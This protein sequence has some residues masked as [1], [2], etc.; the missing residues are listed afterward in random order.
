MRLTELSLRWGVLAALLF[1]TILVPFAIWGETLDQWVAAGSWSRM[2]PG[3]AAGAGMLLLAADVVLPIPSSLIG[4]MLGTMLGAWLGTAAGALGLTAG[5]VLGYAIGRGAGSSGLVRVVP[6]DEFRRAMAWLDRYGVVALVVCRAVPVLAEASVIAAG[7]LRM[8]VVRVLAAT[9][10][11]NIGISAVYA[12][13]G[14][15]ADNAW[16]FVLAFALAMV[17]PGIAMGVAKIAE[18]RL[19][20]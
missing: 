5:C 12:T 1:G 4:T 17:V 11:A 18:R 8:P 13:F 9:T 2:A 7:G 20:S 10:L 19:R 16:G 15:A 14:A 6:A 3:L